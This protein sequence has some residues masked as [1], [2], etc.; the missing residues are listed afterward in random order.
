[1]NAITA[2]PAWAAYLV[3]GALIFGEASTFVGLVIPGETALLAG[4]AMAGTG[5]LSL[6]VLAA[7]AVAAAIL[8]DS[9]GYEVGRL[10]GPRLTNSRAGRLIGPARWD[11]ADQLM[12][13]RGGWAVLA[14]RWVGVLRALMPAIAGA[15]GLPYRRFLIFN[16]TGGALW[17]VTVAVA[18]YLAGASWHRVQAYLG[19]AGLAAA[20]VLAAV[21]TV[22]VLV[23]RRRRRRAQPAGEAVGTG[24][25]M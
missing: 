12:A 7:L 11:R 25:R 1:M 19:D 15:T 14:G 4:G 2:L 8:G 20:G 22:I 9:V 21:V 5:H 3:V 16:A 18:G 23:R 24:S 13:R 6:P 10:L 17:A